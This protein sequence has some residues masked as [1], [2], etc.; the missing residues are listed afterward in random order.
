MRCRVDTIVMYRPRF[1]AR[2]ITGYPD[3]P[4]VVCGARVYHFSMTEDIHNGG[5]RYP[6]C[7]RT[8]VW[9]GW[10]LLLERIDN[11]DGSSKTVESFWGSDLSGTEQGA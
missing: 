7:D 5:A 4:V 8:F 1:S 9:D 3:V 11:A 10:L 6:H 2:P